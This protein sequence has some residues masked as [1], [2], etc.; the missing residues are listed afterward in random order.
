MNNFQ[1]KKINTGRQKE[2]D[3]AKSLPIIFM[4]FVHVL[5]VIQCFDNILSPGYVL[6]ASNILGRPC[7]APVFMFCMG[8]GMIYSRHG[9]WDQMIKR[10]VTLF[11]SGILVNV[12]EFFVPYY[13]YGYL[14]NDWSLFTIAD[15]LLLFCV[16][17]LAF[18]GLT[19]ILIGI[20]KKHDISNIAV[21]I[22]TI[23]MSIIGIL[24]RYTDF[25]VPLLNLFFGYFIGTKGGF[26]AFP[27]F[28]WFIIPVAGD[29]WGYYFIR[30]KDKG[31]FLRYWSICLIIA[32]IYFFAS[33]QIENGFLTDIHQY[34]FM[35]T[36]D[37][38]FCSLYAH[39][40][41]GLCHYLSKF[42]PESIINVSAI[43]SSNINNIYIIQWLFVNVII[44]LLVYIFKGIVFTDWMAIII[45]I[46]IL[47]ISTLY[48]LHYRKIREKTA[49]AKKD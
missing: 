29:V 9:R 44:I 17:I 12:F 14:F 11:L 16:D 5:W 30:A 20:Y 1:I 47:V 19:F 8:A 22:F 13:L 4:V 49:K 23:G 48:S 40:S 6:I 33:T 35:T 2:L 43:L 27:L 21:L 38:F 18:A 36:I 37:V 24:L 25:G 15:G 41:I 39:G 42:L 3:L 7:A 32:F 46:F 31:H 45:S 26:T 28:N 10:G 34:Y